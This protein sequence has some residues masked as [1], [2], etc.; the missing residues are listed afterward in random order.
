MHPVLLLLP[1]EQ[2]VRGRAQKDEVAQEGSDPDPD[3]DGPVQACPVYWKTWHIWFAAT[4]ATGAAATALKLLPVRV[5]RMVSVRRRTSRIFEG[6][7]NAVDWME[8]G[9]FCS[10]LGRKLGIYRQEFRGPSCHCRR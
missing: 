8:R 10:V 7:Y 2:L 4:A 6:G 9:L 3:D 1:L 5:P